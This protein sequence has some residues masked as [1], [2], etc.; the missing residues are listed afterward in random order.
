MQTHSISTSSVFI[1]TLVNLNSWQRKLIA[2]S[3][4]SLLLALSA[5]ISIPTFPVPFSFQSL[6][7]LLTGSFLGRK[8]GSLAIIQYLFIGFIGFPVF[9]DGTFGIAVLLSPSAGYLIG[10][11]LCAYI[12][13][14]AAEKGYD[15]KFLTAMI[16]FA[17]AHQVIFLSGVSYLAFYLQSVESA[18]YLGYVPF[19][20]FDLVK[21]I[22]SSIIMFLL[23][24]QSA[25]RG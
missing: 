1:S 2:T 23:W 3:F 14:A 22:S 25:K 7:V 6:A 5:N 8:L 24:K 4:A 19:M 21:F 18:F 13:G 10:F 15:R 17:I 16:S 12:A 20:G 11:I 9:A